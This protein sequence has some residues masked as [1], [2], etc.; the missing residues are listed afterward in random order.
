[1]TK[2]LRARVR[3]TALR[4]VSYDADAKILTVTFRRGAT[5]SYP[6]VPRAVF[7]AMIKAPSPGRYFRQVVQ[8]RFGK[9]GRGS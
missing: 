4:E 9:D 7:D 2:V 1:V 6:R 3:S 8:A 5:A